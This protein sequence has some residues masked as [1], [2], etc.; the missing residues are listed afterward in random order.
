MTALLPD[1]PVADVPFDRLAQSLDG[2]LLL[3]GD[4]EHTA[5]ATP[6]NV[7]VPPHPFPIVAASSAADVATAVRFAAAHGLQ[8]DVRATGHCPAPVS[9]A[10]L[11]VHTGRLDDVT[12]DPAA[13]TARIGAGVRWQQVLDA[14]SPHGLFGLCGSAPHVGVVGYLTGGGLSPLGRSFGLATDHVR[15]FDVVTGDG[16][17]RHVTPTEDADLFW[18]LRGGKAAAGIVTAVEI[19]LLPLATIHGGTLFFGADD[20]GRVLHTWRRWSATLPDRAATSA[21]ILRLPAMPG[22]PPVLAGETVLAVRFTW[23]GDPAEG[24]EV[25]APIATAATPVL[26]GIGTM[27][28]AAIG[29]VHNDP[30][31]PMP[32]SEDSVV[33]AEFTADTVEALLR[34]AGPDTS[35]PQVV[36]EVRLLGGALERRPEVADAVDHRDGA[37]NLLAIGIAA[38][39]VAE[40]TAASAAQILDAVAPWSTGGSLPNF[41]GPVTP[42]RAGRV[43]R[44]AT[45]E[46]LATVAREHDPHGVFGATAVLHDATV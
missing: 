44:R 20:I 27:P 45:L 17:S 36:V 46:R 33:L 24:D 9:R 23:L 5:L 39:P 35:C 40:A 12:V 10:T 1:A 18:A 34:T 38:P 31:D 29:A 37:Y 13:R 25:I 30:V 2:R 14:A 4:P 43:Y 26:G 19:D 11:L 8:V 32:A 6:W 7:A 42:E 16:V 41:G 21:A 3:L 28:A 22:V 15:A